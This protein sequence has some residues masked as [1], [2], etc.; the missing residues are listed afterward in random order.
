MTDTLTM[1][2]R[3]RDGAPGVG[4]M[5]GGDAR[6]VACGEGIAAEAVDGIG[7]A[8]ETDGGADADPAG[9]VETRDGASSHE[10]RTPEA[11]LG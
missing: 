1:T 5:T 3:A 11:P 8:D 2:Q 4:A 9:G 6:S 10:G 7:G